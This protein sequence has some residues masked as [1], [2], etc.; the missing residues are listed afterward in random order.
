MCEITQTKTNPI[1]SN[2]HTNIKNRTHGNWELTGG[3]EKQGV[4]GRGNQ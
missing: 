1:C 4:G 3:Y 2:L